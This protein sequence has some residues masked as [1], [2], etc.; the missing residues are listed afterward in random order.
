MNIEEVRNIGLSLPFATERCPFG[1][2]TLALEIGGKM[3][4]LLDLSSEW[5]FYNI[6]VDPEYSEQLRERYDSIF[7]AYHMNKRHWV[8][9]RFQGDVSEQLHHELIR[10]AYQQ[11]LKGLPRKLQAALT[12]Q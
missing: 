3:F 7:P 5:D 8:S 10:H 11:T 2:D 9:V 12:I 6:K 4:C 1:P